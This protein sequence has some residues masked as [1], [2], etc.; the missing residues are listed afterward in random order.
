MGTVKIS[1]HGQVFTVSGKVDRD[2]AGNIAFISDAI[3]EHNGEV[4]GHG[5]VTFGPVIC[6]VIEDERDITPIEF[7]E[8]LVEEVI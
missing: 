4:I 3:I 5:S 6:I 2:I 7:E 1:E 8:P